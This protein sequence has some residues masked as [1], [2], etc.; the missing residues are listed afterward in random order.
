MHTNDEATVGKQSA[1][2]RGYYKD[3][4]VA[5][6]SGPATRQLPPLMNR[7]H[8]ARSMVIQTVVERFLAPG[9]QVP[10]RRQIVTLGCGFD[11]LFFRLKA[12]SNDLL[13]ALEQVR[14]LEVDFPAVVANK[15]A[16]LAADERFAPLLA[17]GQYALMAC[18]LRETDEL[19]RT[20]EANGFDRTLPTLFLS[21]CVLIYMSA[22]EGDAIIRWAAQ[23]VPGSLFCTYE[24]IRPHDAF[25]RT[26]IRNL[27]QRNIPLH[28]LLGYPDLQAQAQR[29][30][31]AG[32]GWAEAHDML[33][34][35]AQLVTP[36][37]RSR[38]EKLEPFDEYEEWRLVL[39]HYCL[40]VAGQESAMQKRFLQ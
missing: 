34:A 33:E 37:E 20:L 40:V 28:S 12:Y 4:F 16:V 17:D 14:H 39:S 26:M 7:G 8:F 3:E 27:Q 21:E 38:V 1:V 23:T 29:Y 25:G 36:A 9:G 6:F 13:S 35:Y 10:R 22:E 2:R 18:D 15:K 24:Q 19:T 31:K 32:Y 30:R 5:A 11:T